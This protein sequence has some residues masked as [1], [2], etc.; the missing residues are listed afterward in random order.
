[1][2]R[3]GDTTVRK[4]LTRPPG[5]ERVPTIRV[6]FTPEAKGPLPSFV[7]PMGVMT[8]GRDPGSAIVLDDS[9]TSRLHA[10]IEMDESRLRII[11]ASTNGTYIDGTRVTKAPLE[12]GDVL[13][14]GDSLLLIRMMPTPR[15][16]EA[17]AHGLLG[18]APVMHELRR[19]LSLVALSDAT[20]LVTG[21]SGTGK[22]LIARAIHRASRPN[23]PFIA[24]N[25][26]AI[27]ESVAESQLFGHVSGSF[28]GAREDHLG[29]FRAAN[30]GVLFLD[31]VGELPA[32]MQTKL[33]RALEERAVIPVGAV[34]AIP[35]DVRV[36]AATNRELPREIED[37]RF[38]R[39]LYARLADITLRAPPLRDRV[40]DVIRLMR[41]ALGPDAP[42]LTA[43]LAEALLLHDWP[44]NVRELM[45]V[46]AE[47]RIRGRDLPV[48]DLPL[49]AERLQ[50]RPQGDKKEERAR[51][52]SQAEITAAPSSEEK[53]RPIPTAEELVA[54]LRE[55]GGRIADVA[56][57]T[58]RSR[59]QVYRWLD[60]HGIDVVSFR[61]ES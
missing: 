50:P 33:L 48:L 16:I 2:A 58:G 30:G 32:G 42:P 10:K 19:T 60:T 56:R 13:R 47:L 15:V 1:M 45:K 5:A 7:I 25:C 3:H 28:T 29:F 14:L 59:K 51:R 23:G 34:K 27:A 12:D 8:L 43:D 44:Y 40:E 61:S 4:P 55:H 38:R 53:E 52:T 31:E 36:V 18:D 6:L 49:V 17:E 11:D 9:Q 54:L 20:A 46:A 57:A 35:F 26:G 21:E 39:D 24:V 37:G 41:H 22:E